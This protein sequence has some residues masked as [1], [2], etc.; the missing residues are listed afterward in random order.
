MSSLVC[1]VSGL[2]VAH[3]YLNKLSDMLFWLSLSIATVFAILSLPRWKS[4]A[5]LTVVAL[6]MWWS[7]GRALA[8]YH[9]TNPSPDGRYKLVTYSIPMLF[10]F[11]G[12]GSDASGYVQLQD[13]SGKVLHEGYV[14]MV[15]IVYDAEWSGR[16]V[17]IGRGDGS[18]T[19]ELPE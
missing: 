3:F 14:E 12:Q 13:R 6:S 16:E 4:V 8:A 17:H 9:Y 1:F 7:G 11:P 5:A 10:A 15:Q 18:Y 19:W 2:W